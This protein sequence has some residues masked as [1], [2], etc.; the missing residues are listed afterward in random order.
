MSHTNQGYD[1]VET[2]GGGDGGKWVSKVTSNRDSPTQR[3]LD[4]DQYTKEGG[5]VKIVVVGSG[6]FGRALAGRLVQ[7]GYSVTIASRNP[8]NMNSTLVPAGVEMLGMDSV[9]KA[10]LVIVC[11]PKDF[12]A[13][14]PGPLMAGKVVVDV[15]NRSTSSKDSQSQAEYLS[16]LYPE[17]QVVKAFN[18]LSAYTL[19]NGGMQGS[20]QVFIAGD[21]APAKSLVGE[22]VKGAGFIPVDM[23]G[24][25]S[26]RAIEDIPLALFDGWRTPFYINLGIFSFLYLLAFIK[27]QICWPL[28]WSDQFLWD[29][30]KHI[31][32]D[33]VNK[34]LASHSLTTLALVYTP[35]VLAGWLQIYRGTKYSRFPNWLDRWLRM[36]KQ[37]GLIMFF[38]ACVHACL[39]L[40]T[41]IPVNHELVYGHPEEI[42]VNTVEKI[43]WGPGTVSENKTSVKVFGGEQMEWRG[44]CFLITGVVGFF[45]ISILG[46]TSLPSVTA[47]LSWREFMFVQSRLGWASLLFIVAHDMFYG[48]PY[49][50]SPSCG[51]PSGFQYVLYIPGL[52]ILMKIPLVLPPLSTHLDNIRGGYVRTKGGNTASQTV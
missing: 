9:A 18:V 15:S 35:G 31:P 39:S 44:E 12:Y 38:C 11:I 50:N 23:G 1:D 30:W 20:K 37:M 49:M 5:S 48:W 28:T 52:T 7:S 33:N 41:L 26:A 4:T 46:L 13:S 32:M 17:C 10:D 14:L 29:L 25:S 42:F 16:S 3:D 27:F 6:N 47:T 19:E 43:G 2:P 40:A 45:L 24:L 36:R 8:D 21:S 51:I 22:V 34:V